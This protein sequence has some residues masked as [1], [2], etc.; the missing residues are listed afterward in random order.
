[1]ADLLFGL[2]GL[3]GALILS[4]FYSG[5]ETAAYAASPVRLQYLGA[6]GDG[7]AR[8]AAERL[9]DMARLVTVILVGNNLAVYLGSHITERLLGG[10]GWR[11]TEL[12]T[13][14]LLTPTFFLFAETA[15]KQ[16]GY[17]L[18]DR[19]CRQGIRVMT[20]SEWLFYPLVLALGIVARGL[21]A[22]LDHLGHVPPPATRRDEIL[23]HLESGLDEGI[24]DPTQHRMA[25][26]VAGMERKRLRAI[27][28]PLNEIVSVKRGTPCA[29]AQA[30][31]HETG[32]R[33]LPVVD[34]RRQEVLGVLSAKILTLQDP[35]PDTPAAEVMQPVAQIPSDTSLGHACGRLQS[36][37]GK[38]AAVTRDGRAVGIV[39]VADLVSEVLGEAADA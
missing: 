27:A 14:L 34:K 28:T 7:L 39:T 4:A 1:M 15:P 19:Y 26:H 24:L 2:L 22:V 29:R 16:L 11:Q 3:T 8:R 21:R 25:L 17:F 23:A 5:M 10:L 35:A 32:L 20:V 38:L 37:G 13:T 9:A 18:A 30:I 12:W 33:H 6:R 31:M 36:T